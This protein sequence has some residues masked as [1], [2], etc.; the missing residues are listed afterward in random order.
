[1][2]VAQFQIIDAKKRTPV[3]KRFTDPTNPRD[4]VACTDLLAAKARILKKPAASLLLVAY[5]RGNKVDEY[6]TT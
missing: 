5:E 4:A 3:G 1:M 2:T 6:S